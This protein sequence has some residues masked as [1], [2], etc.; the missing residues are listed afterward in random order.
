MLKINGFDDAILGPAWIWRDSEVV[1]VIVYDAEQIRA[2]LMKR[3]GMSPEVAREYIEFNIEG[4]Y[5]GRHTPVLV[6]PHDHYILGDD[7]E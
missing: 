3:E 5:V 4:A 1:S 7:N 6:W 2:I